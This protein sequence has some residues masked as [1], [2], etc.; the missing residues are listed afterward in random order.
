MNRLFA[1]FLCLGIRKRTPSRLPF[2]LFP[3]PL[4]VQSFASRPYWA[5]L[6]VSAFRL[7]GGCSSLSNTKKG[8]A[9]GTGAGA[10]AG[11][12]IG[13]AAGGTA[14]GA[15]I[16]A[17]LGG[18]AGALIGRRMGRKAQELD[19]KLADADVKRVGEGIVVT[20]D[21]GLLFDFNSSTLQGGAR[22]N[23]REFAES[24]NEFQETD[25]LIVGHTDAKG[26]DEYNQGMSE[27]RVQ[28]ATDF[29][30]QQG[31]S[32]NRIRTEGRG[33]TEPIA[34]NETA[35][36]RTLNRRVEVAIFASEEYRESAQEQAKGE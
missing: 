23:L 3:H 35:E 27:R 36:G 30:V 26:A 29:L 11:A 19:E 24:M 28:S 34:T 2:S 5:A 14:E 21:S 6:L 18:T 13:K 17:V 7:S 9:I 31:I 8:A 25:I 22:Q 10:A 16:G 15:V 20:F 32:A 12:A 4:Y 33:E 1:G